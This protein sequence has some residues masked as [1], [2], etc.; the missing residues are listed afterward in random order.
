MRSSLFLAAFKW[1][2]F[3]VVSASA[4][5]WVSFHGLAQQ[6]PAPSGDCPP[7]TIANL[8]RQAAFEAVRPRLG[9]KGYAAS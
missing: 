6:P 3:T 2:F 9:C 1:I 7:D 8:A 4:V 5:L